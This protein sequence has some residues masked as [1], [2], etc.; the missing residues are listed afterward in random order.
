MQHPD[1]IA[2]LA[3]YPQHNWKH[4]VTISQLN[5]APLWYGR[6]GKRV[7]SLKNTVVDS[8]NLQSPKYDS[9]FTK[10]FETVTDEQCQLWLKQKSNRPWVVFWSG[11]TDST[12]ILTA[13]LKHTTPA[14][15]QN[16]RVAC[17]RVSVYENPYFFYDHVLPNFKIIDSQTL[18]QDYEFYDTHYILGGDLADQLYGGKLPIWCAEQFSGGMTLDCRREPDILLKS[19]EAKANREFAEWYYERMMTN[20]DSVDAP[21]KTYYDFGWWQFYNYGW[22]GFILRDLFTNKKTRDPVLIKK[23]LDSALYWYGSDD[24]QQWIMNNNQNRI[25]HGTGLGET[26]LPSKQ[27]IYEFDHN[28]YYRMFKTK[29]DSTSIASYSDR[30]V[31]ILDDYSCL[32]VSD[33]P[34]VLELL[35][36]H[37]ESV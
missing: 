27:Y 31:C 29:H 23:Y 15:R 16:I 19:L 8:M 20:I 33:L 12:L 10:T 6:E 21:V 25:K 36:E 18:V 3:Q 1:V 26:K 17:N 28:E 30:P 34:R 11:G 37:I 9:S 22:A 13:I 24:Y 4:L 32:F 5:D 14:D 35:P 7:F 2:V